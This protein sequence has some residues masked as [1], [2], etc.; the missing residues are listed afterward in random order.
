M[1]NCKSAE[2]HGIL[3]KQY[4]VLPLVFLLCPGGFPMCGDIP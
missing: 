3:I 2:G 1:G 4:K